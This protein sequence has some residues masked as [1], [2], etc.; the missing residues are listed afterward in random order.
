LR[1]SIVLPP[2][3]TAEGYY[4]PPESKGGWR[5]LALPR[6]AF[7]LEGFR[8]NRC[9]IIPSLDLVVARVGSGPPTWDEGLIGKIVA[10]AIAS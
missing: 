4:P 10:A 3:Q 1:R 7:A 5:W 9:Y 8:P 6:A 2:S